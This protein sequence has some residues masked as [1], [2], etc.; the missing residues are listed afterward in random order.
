MHI[1]TADKR[2]QI[3]GMKMPT[4]FWTIESFNDCSI[5]KKKS[6]I[7]LILFYAVFFSECWSGLGFRQG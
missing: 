1:A 3:L 2:L 7:K 6:D 4:Y 5:C